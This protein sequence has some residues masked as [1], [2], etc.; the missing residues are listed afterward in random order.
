MGR[1]AQGDRSALAT[2]YDELSP[3]LFGI[4][5]RIIGERPEAEDV[6]HDVFLEAWRNAAEY[7]PARGSVLVWLSLRMRSRAIDKL[8]SASR[9]R[10]VR[11]DEVSE[12]QVTVEARAELE[13]D[14]KRVRALLE[15]LAPAQREVLALGYY[16][17]LS[18]SEIADV[19]D[20]PIG[21]VK[22]RVAGAMSRLRHE[23][24]SEREA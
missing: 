10:F 9:R 17:G 7:S 23:L 6:V 22:S 16:S 5:V 2:L 8:R 18:S 24:G 4:G 14:H 13:I 3:V 1:V 15:G 11:W 19:L 20:I 21:T 12:A